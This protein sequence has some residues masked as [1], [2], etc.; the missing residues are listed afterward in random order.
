MKK[1]ARGSR[2]VTCP[3]KIPRQPGQSCRVLGSFILY[4]WLSSDLDMASWNL[5]YGQ[6]SAFLHYHIKH[7]FEYMRL[8]FGQFDSTFNAIKQLDYHGP[9]IH[10]RQPPDARLGSCPPMFQHPSRY[11]CHFKA[12]GCLCQLFPVVQV[13]WIKLNNILTVIN[14]LPQLSINV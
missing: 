13:H 4:R 12:H 7:D 9:I 1:E 6:H 2:K 3:R 5:A 11:K 10:L 8:Q 14:Y